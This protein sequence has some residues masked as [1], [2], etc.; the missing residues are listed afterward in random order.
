MEHTFGIVKGR[1]R[2]L[3]DAKLTC[4]E[5]S[6][7]ARCQAIIQ[8]CFILHNLCVATWQDYITEEGARRKYGSDY[9]ER[10]R[11]IEQNNRQYGRIKEEW[12]RRENLVDDMLE[13]EPE[14]VI[15]EDF[16]M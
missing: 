4:K 15:L 6:D 12:M 14:E 9:M 16:V 2:I 11:V 13:L 10:S 3:T 7:Q 5:A 8:A 1:W